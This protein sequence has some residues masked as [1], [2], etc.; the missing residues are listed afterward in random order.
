MQRAW[1]RRR[2][3]RQDVSIQTELFE[4]LFMPYSK[5]MLF[6]Y[7]YEAKIREC[8]VRAQQAMRADDDIYFLGFELSKCIFLFL[9]RLKARECGDANGEVCETIAECAEM[10]IGENCRGNKHGDLA[11]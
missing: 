9:R 2:R 4:A 3:Q 7:D 1:N 8:D 5:A 11:A 6:I 10:L